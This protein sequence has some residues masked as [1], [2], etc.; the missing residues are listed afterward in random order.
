MWGGWGI[1]E[2]RF[3]KIITLPGGYPGNIYCFLNKWAYL[4]PVNLA[5][6]LGFFCLR[7]DYFRIFS[8]IAFQLPF[9]KNTNGYSWATFRALLIVLYA[10]GK[11]ACG[12]A[13]T[14]TKLAALHVC[15]TTELI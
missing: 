2:A 11:V 15:S 5:S 8:V 7:L 3:H 10:Q 1:R 6:C 4:C 13:G 14:K 12:I 9:F